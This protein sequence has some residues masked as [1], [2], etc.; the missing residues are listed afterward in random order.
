MK[1]KYECKYCGKQFEAWPSEKRAGACSKK[2][3]YKIRKLPP[4]SGQ[5]KKGSIPPYAGKEMPKWL[6]QKLSK[7]RL[8]S[9]KVRG[10][11]HYKW[12]GG[13]S[14]FLLKVARKVMLHANIKK[15]CAFCKTNIRV[16]VHHK[17]QNQRD[18]SLSNL[19]YLCQ[20]CHLRLHKYL[21][22]LLKCQN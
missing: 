18:N 8:G 13:K 7:A 6:R 14:S 15:E 3:G 12:K 4:N 22:T 9:D 10:A 17:N 2:C 19:M 16:H 1:N 11:R 20:P 21:I 5:F